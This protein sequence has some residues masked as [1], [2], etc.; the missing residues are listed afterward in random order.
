MGRRYNEGLHQAIEAKEGV[1][2]ARESKTLAT[3]TFQNYFRMYDKLSGM[4]GT[5]HDRGGR[6]RGRSTSCDVV[7]IPTNKPVARID[8]TDVVYKTEPAK[9]NAVIEQIIECHEKGQ[10]VLVGTISIE[11]SR[12]VEQAAEPPRR[13]ARGI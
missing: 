6:V 2:V 8:Y 3:I 12:A 11:K 4:T 9:F 5:A 10:P 7:E 1:K 13:E